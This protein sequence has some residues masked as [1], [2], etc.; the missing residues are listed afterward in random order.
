LKGSHCTVDKSLDDDDYDYDDDDDDDDVS[1][2]YSNTGIAIILQTL[3]MVSFFIQN[4]HLCTNLE[5]GV[6]SRSKIIAYR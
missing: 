5:T 4:G 3:R 2:P 1:K 6:N